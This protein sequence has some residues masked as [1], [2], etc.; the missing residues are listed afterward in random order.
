M[1]RYEAQLEAMG[2]LENDVAGKSNFF[3]TLGTPDQNIFPWIHLCLMLPLPQGNI[4]QEES[5]HKTSSD[6]QAFTN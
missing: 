6:F 2:V 1:F 3:P 4:K 5:L